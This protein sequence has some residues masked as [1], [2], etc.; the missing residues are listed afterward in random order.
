MHT[1]T[2][3]DE[4]KHWN[5][6]VGIPFDREISLAFNDLHPGETFFHVGAGSLLKKI[7]LQKGKK[8]WQILDVFYVIV[9]LKRSSCC[10]QEWIVYKANSFSQ[11]S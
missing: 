2:N 3:S 1:K 4:Y 6:M 9:K 10:P 7:A 8:K 11:F 5:I